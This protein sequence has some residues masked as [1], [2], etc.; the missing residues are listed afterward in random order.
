MLTK[1]RQRLTRLIRDLI[2]QFPQIDFDVVSNVHVDADLACLAAAPHFVR[3]VGGFSDIVEEVRYQRD[4][5]HPDPS[6]RIAALR[7][8]GYHG[9]HVST[10]EKHIAGDSRSDPV[11][12][13]GWH[14]GDGPHR[15]T[16]HDTAVLLFHI[17]PTPEAALRLAFKSQGDQPIVYRVN[18]LVVQPFEDGGGQVIVPLEEDGGIMLVSLESPLYRAKDQA[19][20]ENS[21][22]LG[23]VLSDL[24]LISDPRRSGSSS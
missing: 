21:P 16:R 6:H 23:A 15:S 12:Y 5:T 22:P 18:G 2:W 24:E 4:A 7:R 11:F 9:P 10:G 1:N 8:I 20:F 17:R 3:D 19:R 14:P 13:S